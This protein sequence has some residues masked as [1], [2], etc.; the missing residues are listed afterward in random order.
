MEP[1]PKQTQHTRN[2][3]NAFS[4]IYDLMEWPIEQFLYRPWRTKLWDQVKGPKVLEIGIGTGKNISYHPKDISITGID[5]SPKMLQH[6]RKYAGQSHVEN[7]DLLEMDA[8]QLTFPDNTFDD[9]VAT[10]AFCSVP[11]PVLGLQEALRVTKTGGHL[12]LLEHMR[13]KNSGLAS[14]MKMLDAPIHY[15]MGVHI[16]RKTV[17]NVEK[18]GWH[19][20]NV[21]ELTAGGIFRMIKAV[22]KT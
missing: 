21:E 7:L 18:A 16:A 9:T 3:Y 1:D 2:R 20:D 11:D 22:K 6:A 8:Q 5:L 10:F 15:L 17:E 13:S 19:I 14:L 4:T 12:F